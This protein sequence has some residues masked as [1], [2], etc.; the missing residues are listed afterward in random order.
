MAEDE[1]EL[2][3]EEQA[4]YLAGK[5][6]SYGTPPPHI[7]ELTK[8]RYQNGQYGP[9]LAD[10]DVPYQYG[11]DLVPGGDHSVEQRDQLLQAGINQVAG[12]MMEAED[13][14]EQTPNVPV[15]DVY[16]TDDTMLRVQVTV[17]DEGHATGYDENDIRDANRPFIPVSWRK[18]SGTVANL[19][20][21]EV[22]D[23]NGYL[24][25]AWGAREL[26][27]TYHFE[28]EPERTPA[29][30]VRWIQAR[31]D[32]QNDHRREAGEPPIPV[33]GRDTCATCAAPLSN[34]GLRH[35]K[36]WICVDGIN[37]CVEHGQEQERQGGYVAYALAH[38]GFDPNWTCQVCGNPINSEG[39]EVTTDDTADRNLLVRC[40][41]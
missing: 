7:A 1:T 28:Q 2:T 27:I 30:I 29:E 24:I 38:E 6:T 15:V 3:P 9:N 4:D 12:A 34:V 19:Y 41:K 23:Q 20:P 14:A 36:P 21:V 26:Q 10:Q 18:G 32:V 8:Y 11:P 13:R 39:H 16:H 31:V 5:Y 33:I 17:E 22:R 25:G 37:Y 35:T 40:F